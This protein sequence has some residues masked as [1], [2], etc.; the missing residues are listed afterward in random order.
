MASR[1]HELS[2]DDDEA[3][4]RL[5]AAFVESTRLGKL[6]EALALVD[7]RDGFWIGRPEHRA[8]WLYY[9]ATVFM[10]GA[11]HRN[12][13]ADL[14]EARG[15]FA[16]LEHREEALDATATLSS[17]YAALGRDDE[18]LRL[19]SSVDRTTLPTDGCVAFFFANNAAFA[20]LRSAERATP[21][22]SRN[23]A[24]RARALEEAAS[25]LAFLRAFP[26]GACSDEGARSLTDVHEAEHAKLAGLT[27]RLDELL[28]HATMRRELR[29]PV[30]E[31]A[32]AELELA[33]ASELHDLAAGERIAARL[34]KDAEALDQP[35]S[36]WA[37]HMALARLHRRRSMALARRELEAAEAILDRTLH[38][39]AVGDGRNAFLSAHEASAAELFDLLLE[40]HAYDDALRLARKSARRAIDAAAAA[41]TSAG[42]RSAA[43]EAALR[44]YREVKVQTEEAAAHDWELPTHEVADARQRRGD[45][46]REARRALEAA[47]DERREVQATVVPDD[48]KPAADEALLAVH[49]TSG[50]YAALVIDRSGARV[51]RVT[52]DINPGEREAVARELLRGTVAQL[53][54][55]TTV[56]LTAYGPLRPFDWTHAAL[57]DLGTPLVARFALVEHL[58]L[59]PTPT[60]SRNGAAVVV[61]DAAGD[62]PYAAREG[63]FVRE[64]LSAD[65]LRGEQATRVAV[66]R[67]IESSSFVHYAGHGRFA[68]ADGFE[69]ELLLASGST[70]SVSDVLLLDRVPAVAVLSGCELARSDDASGESFGIAQAMLA[71]G[72]RYAIAPSRT[73]KDTL[74][75]RF[76]HALYEDGPLDEAIVPRRMQAALR[77]LATELPHE[78]WSTF[79]LLAR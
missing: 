25:W 65:E 73:V 72:G 59:G 68:G 75:E 53:A 44:T 41:F 79:R 52:R 35:H 6:S 4:G 46:L 17:V 76:V 15:L 5:T 61:A 26:T 19:V 78:D 70:L 27:S 12:A 22:W 50:G 1:A 18:A 64:R 47:F 57:D 69:S 8:T 21:P 40:T 7:D 55:G 56:H 10:Y 63:A 66:T 33:R 51:A 38:D 48:L 16:Q 42:A 37:A 31:L 9:R 29:L 36:A 43:Q 58:G 2:L 77:A 45:D 39:V 20:S 13:I 24:A 34:L 14:T 62:L 32:W 54:E 71:R 11:A 74:A 3:I 23:D 49:P 60:L 67:A 30:V 28:V